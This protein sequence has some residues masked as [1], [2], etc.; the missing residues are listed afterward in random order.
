MSKSKAIEIYWIQ[1]AGYLL[2]P[3][4][5][6]FLKNK[7]RSG[8]TNPKKNV[9]NKVKELSKVGQTEKIDVWVC[10]FSNC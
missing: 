6:L 4:K 9:W 7:K 10:V 3:H 5:K 8:T 1:D 2:L